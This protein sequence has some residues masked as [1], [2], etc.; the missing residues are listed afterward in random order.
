MY[1]FE[2]TT[3]PRQDHLEKAEFLRVRGSKWSSRRKTACYLRA[4]DSVKGCALTGD[5]EATRGWKHLYGA[6]ENASPEFY[7][8]QKYS[9]RMRMK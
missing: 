8:W 2:F 5:A 7:R 1:K 3:N 6:E 4:S 9:S